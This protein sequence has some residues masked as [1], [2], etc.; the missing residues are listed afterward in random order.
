M[1]STTRAD[2]EVGASI[3]DGLLRVRVAGVESLANTIAYWRVIVATLA[4]ADS[5]LVLLVDE[6]R[7]GTPLT[8]Q[9]WL[10]LVV[11]MDGAGLDKARIA[12]VKPL[13]PSEIEYCEIYA[14]DAGIDARVFLRERE[15]IAWLRTGADA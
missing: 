3:E 13:G 4:E 8:D 9:D 5:R 6:L 14:R 11:M 7:A 10:D 1:E 2:L 15:A 12:H